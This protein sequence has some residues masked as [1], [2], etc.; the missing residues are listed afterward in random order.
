MLNLNSTI[1]YYIGMKMIHSGDG[2]SAYIPKYN[3]CYV[4]DIAIVIRN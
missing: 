4:F 2:L 3:S 1:Y